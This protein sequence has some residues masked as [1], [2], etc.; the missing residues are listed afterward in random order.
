MNAQP[1]GVAV[2][3]ALYSMVCAKPI[4][5]LGIDVHDL[6]TVLDLR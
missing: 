3:E 1:M 6:G 4:N 5:R 2:N